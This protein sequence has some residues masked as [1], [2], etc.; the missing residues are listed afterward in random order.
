MGGEEYPA[1][2]GKIRREPDE[3]AAK[4]VCQ[5]TSGSGLTEVS[6]NTH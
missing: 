3:A 4:L 6:H 5:D 2:S 1:V